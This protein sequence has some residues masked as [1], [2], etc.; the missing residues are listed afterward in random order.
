MTRPSGSFQ[1]AP[2]PKEAL[3]SRALGGPSQAT[4]RDAWRSLSRLVRSGVGIP[5][6]LRMLSGAGSSTLDRALLRAS[7]SVEGGAGLAEALSRQPGLLNAEEKQMLG[8]AEQLGDIAPVLDGLADELQARIALRR[9]LIRRAVYPFMLLISTAV[10]G[11]LP[12][13]ITGG[14]GAYLATVS[15][16]LALIALVALG[17]AFGV[18]MLL[19]PQRVNEALRHLAWRLPMGAGAYQDRIRARFSR[20]LGRNLE[21]GLPLY[22]SLESAAAVTADPGV[23]ERAQGAAAE[24]SAG[25]E[26]VKALASMSLFEAGD[27]M[28]LVSA[29]RSG[30]L[31]QTFAQLAAHYEERG[32]RRLK[33]IALIASGI[34]TGAVLVFVASGIIMAYK[35]AVL[36]PLELLEQEM[37][38]LK[39]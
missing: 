9:E 12:L 39:R 31:A 6:S 18:P 7:A 20:V 19:R 33:R 15:K 2:E 5:E 28:Q 3:W 22:T 37:P 21:S 38:H 14:A 8:A 17:L 10:V 24:L 25:E 35:E 11:P 4:R 27:R 32:Q 36:G 26:L 13:V 34:L 16:S 23:V 1:R 30:T 29:E